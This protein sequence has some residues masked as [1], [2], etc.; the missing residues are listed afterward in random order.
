MTENRSEIG[1]APTNARRWVA[2][3][4]LVLLWFT[5]SSCAG[6]FD[7]VGEAL[8][9]VQP[10]LDDAV[11]NEPYHA[12]IHAVGGLRPYHFE[13]RSGAL[14]EG[15]TLEN[16]AL[17]GT[18][19]RTG[20]F[21]FSVAVSDAN[22]ATTVQEYRLV[23]VELPP[24]TFT[25]DPP[26]TELREPVTLRA[27]VAG[28]RGLRALRVQ[29]DW[30]PALF[31]LRP[32]SVAASGRGLALLSAGSEEEGR[33]QVDVA[34][35]GATIDGE[36]T[37][38]TLTLEP[39]EEPA[40]LRLESRV[41]FLSEAADPGRVHHFARVDEGQRPAGSRPS[42]EDAP[43]DDTTEDPLDDPLEDP[44]DDPGDDDPFDEPGDDD[45]FDDPS[46]GSSNGAAGGQDEGG[47]QR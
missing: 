42:D 7:T 43:G 16:G 23:V 25:L 18:P 45:P 2:A 10:T 19:G 32:G 34:A 3:L 28:A 22:L 11:L 38:F 35:L 4:L 13:L 30:D 9:L 5:L 8:R 24:P 41:E 44:F 46:S 1:S 12:P 33:L 36:R 27:S 39:L 15:V 37:L 6:E 29:V 21:E 17:R 14:P 31:R 40:S 26:L 20:T 47:D